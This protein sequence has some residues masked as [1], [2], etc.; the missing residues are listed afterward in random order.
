MTDEKENSSEPLLVKGPSPEVLATFQKHKDAFELRV[1]PALKVQVIMSTILSMIFWAVLAFGM[2]RTF[3]LSPWAAVLAV[4]LGTV[5]GVSMVGSSVSALMPLRR[6]PIVVFFSCLGALLYQV[7]K[8]SFGG[9]A[10]GSP[11]FLGTLPFAIWSAL[12]GT[13]GFSCFHHS[14]WWNKVCFVSYMGATSDAAMSNQAW[15]MK[16]MRTYFPETAR[17]YDHMQQ[18]RHSHGHAHHEH[19]HQHAGNG[20]SII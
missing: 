13:F 3:R 7:F 2:P 16:F 17:R 18:Q 10:F 9:G 5:C 4:I 14:A 11:A 20:P 19:M 6:M 12:F 1:P 15:Q 8:V